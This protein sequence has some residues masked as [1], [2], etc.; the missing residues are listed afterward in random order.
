MAISKM[1]V[2]QQLR[3]WMTEDQTTAIVGT[4][5][6]P[7]TLHLLFFICATSSTILIPPIAGGQLIAKSLSCDVLA[8]CFFFKLIE[9]L[10]PWYLVITGKF[11]CSSNT[12]AVI[13][14]VFIVC[15]HSS[16]SI[17]CHSHYTSCVLSTHSSKYQSSNGIWPSGDCIMTIT[18]IQGIVPQCMIV[19]N[20]TGCSI[21]THCSKHQPGRFDKEETVLWTTIHGMIPTCMI[22][23]NGKHAA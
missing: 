19:A 18:D 21:S 6:W 20:S 16:S 14:S 15:T 17:H 5:D 11:N 7:C 1:P 4:T 2:K 9:T 23:T 3:D 22:V 13:F 8:S 12:A 10:L